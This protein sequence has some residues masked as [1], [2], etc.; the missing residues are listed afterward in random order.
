MATDRRLTARQ[1]RFCTEYIVD[2]NATAAAIRAGYSAKTAEQIGWQLLQK[3]SVQNRIAELQKSRAKRVQVT[4]DDV[5]RELMRLGFSDIR[6]VATWAED[7]TRLIDSETITEDAART[8][9]EISSV[10][11]TMVTDHGA[12]TT[13][14]TKIK[15]HSK[16]QALRALGEHLGLFDGD[17][18]DSGDQSAAQPKAIRYL[19]APEEPMP[20]DDDGE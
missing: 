8:I 1:E 5:L 13:T 6:G 9:S 10:A 16:M 19:R 20:E 7:G 4:A 11:T 17:S 14:R 15:L 2:L 12:V 18:D 3:T